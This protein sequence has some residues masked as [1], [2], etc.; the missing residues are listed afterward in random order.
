PR[1]DLADLRRDA[2]RTRDPDLEAVAPHGVE[3][4]GGDVVRLDE[5]QLPR[6]G[7]AVEHLRVDLRRL[8]QREAQA[9]AAVLEAQRLRQP[10]DAV[11][12]RRID[13]A[14]RQRHAANAGGDVDDVAAPARKHATDREPGA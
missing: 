13:G 5:R 11:L 8:Y 2:L 7:L 3:H 9:A 6:A 12:R 10:D 14:E 1:S 4:R